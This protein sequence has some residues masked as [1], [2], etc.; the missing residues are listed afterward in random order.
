MG[1]IVL[2]TNSFMS[3][4][5]ALIGMFL[6]SGTWVG[7]SATPIPPPL[8]CVDDIDC[9]ETAEPP[10]APAPGQ[11]YTLTTATTGLPFAFSTPILPNITSEATVTPSTIVAN[12]VNGR[13]IF[14]SPGIYGDQNF[15]TTDLEIVIGPGVEISTITFGSSAR[16]LHFRADPI[17]SGL[18][19][20]IST[21]GSSNNSLTDLFFDGILA[22]DTGS[23]SQNQFHGT[24]VAVINSSLTADSYAMGNFH[25]VTDFL[26]ANSYIYTYGSTQSNMRSHS[27]LR[28]VVV[29]SRLRKGGIG[30]AT[31][32]VHG[33]DGVSTRPAHNIYIARNQLDGA[34][35]QIRGSGTSGPED[36]VSFA[37]ASAGIDTAWFENNTLYQPGHNN[38]SLYAGTPTHDSDRPKML[39]LLNNVLYSDRATWLS[40][41]QPRE[42]WVLQNNEHY[43]YQPPPGWSFR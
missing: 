9:V 18:I 8:L 34:R 40:P 14:L 33:D 7:L 12:K 26:V 24:R 31:L 37:N 29:D 5:R 30:H 11:G 10:E 43:P 27:A 20:T 6:V 36:G 16:R 21:G 41:S 19:R 3:G 2:R 38:A 32:R 22:D 4:L 23:P 39:Y 15:N 42:D 28:Y 25:V 17:R 1:E 35:V 13:R